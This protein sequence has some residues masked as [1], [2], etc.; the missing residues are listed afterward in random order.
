M[1]S[2]QHCEH[3]QVYCLDSVNLIGRSSDCRV[4]LDNGYASAHHAQLRWVISENRWEIKDFCSRNGTFVNG[5][6]LSS[7]SLVTLQTGMQLAFGDPADTFLLVCDGPPSPWASSNDGQLQRADGE[8]LCLP[9][10]NDPR[11]MIMLDYTGYWVIESDSGIKRVQ[12]G[13]VL[14]IDDRRWRIYLPELL[15]RTDPAEPQSLRLQ[16]VTLRFCVNTIG[17]LYRIEIVHAGCIERSLGYRKYLQ[18]LL[19]L[20]HAYIEDRDSG[21]PEQECGWRFTD[22]TRDYITAQEAQDVTDPTEERRLNN[23]LS[24]HKHRSKRALQ[25]AGIID[26]DTIFDQRVIAERERQLRLTTPYLEIIN[27][28]R[29]G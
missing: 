9:S 27:V 8:M 26:A 29:N 14:N 13:D 18:P 28:E 6:R 7:D 3:G 25:V 16:D 20:A 19:T 21:L 1:G 23:L 4:R 11:Y 12:S 17:A 5:S 15:P 2:L 24:L 22:I 10:Q